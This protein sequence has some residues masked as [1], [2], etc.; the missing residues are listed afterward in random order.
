M[1]DIVHISLSSLLKYFPAG[2]EISYCTEYGPVKVN[3]YI[4]SCG[5]LLFYTDYG[6]HYAVPGELIQISMEDFQRY[7]S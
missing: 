1:A 5:E 7:M 6:L 4:W 2:T 3:E